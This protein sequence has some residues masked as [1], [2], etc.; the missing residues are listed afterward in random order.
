MSSDT[1]ILLLGICLI[2]RKQNHVQI[3][4]HRCQEDCMTWGKNTQIQRI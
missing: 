1:V 2:E 4:I 3:Y